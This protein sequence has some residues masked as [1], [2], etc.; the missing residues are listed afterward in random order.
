MSKAIIATAR[1]I[2]AEIRAQEDS[3]DA[4]LA[5]QARLLGSLLDARRITNVPA[6]LGA[7]ALDRAFE[8]LTHG[9]MLR[10]SMLAMHRELAGMNLRELGFGDVVPCPEEGNGRLSLVVSEDTKA[11]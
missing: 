11:A 10:E 5:G 2:A 3:V 9:R 7:V 1:Q 4:A 8:A 6:Q